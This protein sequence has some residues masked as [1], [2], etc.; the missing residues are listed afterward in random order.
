MLT[1]SRLG[2]RSITYYNDTADR[3]KSSATKHHTAGDGLAEYYTEGETRVPSWLVVGDKPFIAAA[4]GLG[5]SALDG[6]D[7]DTEVARVWL[8]DGRA[9]SGAIGREFTEK[10]VHGFDLT[11]SAPKSVSL[12]RAL[13]DDIAEKVLATAHTQ[14]VHAAMT[15]TSDQGL[16]NSL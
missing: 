12:V 5:G 15:R 8:D 14:A 13:T 11:F 16:A 7:A 6:G 4:T 10:S 1:I 9:P 2:H 3:A